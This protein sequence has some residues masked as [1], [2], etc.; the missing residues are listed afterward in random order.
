MKNSVNTTKE[1]VYSELSEIA[2]AL[3]AP[4]RLRIIQ[5]LSNRTSSVE[6]LSERIGESVANTSQHLQ[7]LRKAGLVQVTRSGVSRTYSLTNKKVIDVFLDLQKVGE[8][9]SSELKSAETE[10]CPPELQSETSVQ[11]VIKAVK[12]GEATLIDV[13]DLDEF[14]SSTAP[15]AIYFP[16]EEMTKGLKLLSKKKPVFAF[17]RGRYC[18]LANDVV[19]QL[20]K[21]GFE[22]YRLREMAHEILALSSSKEA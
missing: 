8:L 20:R 18:V 5:V 17:C 2:Q 9:L 7:K 12:K 19:V 1:K 4:A 14:E 15:Q 16:R 6:D 11:D 21:R 10:F 3:G 22:A 13:R